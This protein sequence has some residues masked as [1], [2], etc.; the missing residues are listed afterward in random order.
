MNASLSGSFQVYND[1]VDWM[2]RRAFV[3]WDSVLCI[4]GERLYE[5]LVSGDSECVDEKVQRKHSLN[6][7]LAL[8]S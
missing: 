3:T 2:H 7:K 8:C 5:I 4:R 6:S 1:I